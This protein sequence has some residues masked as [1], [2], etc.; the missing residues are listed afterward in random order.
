MGGMWRPD[1]FTS[2]IRWFLDRPVMS[3]WRAIAGWLL[4]QVGVTCTVNPVNFVDGSSVS[5]VHQTV[6]VLGLLN[7]AMLAALL[8]TFAAV[9]VLRAGGRL[10]SRHAA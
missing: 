2:G 8:G 5:H 1:G 6:I 9:L 3:V 7:E 10:Q 4:F